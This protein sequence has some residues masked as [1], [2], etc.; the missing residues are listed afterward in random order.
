MKY[1]EV[2]ALS[3]TRAGK[4]HIVAAL[5]KAVFVDTVYIEDCYSDDPIENT[6]LSQPKNKPWY[7]QHKRSK[8]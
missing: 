3:G 6:Y 7:H 8:Y 2:I 5:A 4:S 1:N